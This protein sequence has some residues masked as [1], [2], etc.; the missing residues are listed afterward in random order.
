M[1]NNIPT[2]EPRNA[3]QAGQAALKLQIR[4]VGSETSEIRKDT[5]RLRPT[6]DK[7]WGGIQKLD[8]QLKAIASKLDE[9]VVP[10]LMEIK[11][12]VETD[13]A[14]VDRATAFYGLVLKPGGEFKGTEKATSWLLG[15]ARTAGV[16]LQSVKD[17]AALAEDEVERLKESLLDS[18]HKFPGL[19]ERLTDGDVAS[20]LRRAPSVAAAFNE[21]Q[22]AT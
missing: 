22:T 1:P 13:G 16:T 3:F 2:F 5:T 18:R 9:T 7:A 19:L 12:L 15:A 8:D 20:I 14:S 11:E 21:E 17:L 4:K 10:T 6:V